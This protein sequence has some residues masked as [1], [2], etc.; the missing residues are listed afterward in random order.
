VACWQLSQ[1]EKG[2]GK[3]YATVMWRSESAL[4][5]EDADLTTAEGLDGSN[6]D[7]LEERGAV[8]GE[9]PRRVKK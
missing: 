6:Y 5:A 9:R 7:L 2:D 8:L 4:R 3:V 1:E